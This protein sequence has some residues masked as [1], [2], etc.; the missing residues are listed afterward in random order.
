MALS[1]A[2]R[3]CYRTQ[4]GGTLSRVE[5]IILATI[6]QDYVVLV[7]GAAASASPLGEQRR[8]GSAAY[9]RIR[10]AVGNVR[11]M[12]LDS[13]LAQLASQHD[14]TPVA[15]TIARGEV[16]DA[17][18]ALY[19]DI[20]ENYAS[21][22]E[23]G[24]SSP[25][26]P[27]GQAGNIPA[28]D[29]FIHVG[30]AGAAGDPG[31][32]GV[33]AL[34]RGIREEARTTAARV[35]AL[36]S[37]PRPSS[38]NAGAGGARRARSPSMAAGGLPASSGLGLPLGSTPSSRSMVQASS[39]L[40]FSGLWDQGP[41]VSTGVLRASGTD[42][43]RLRQTRV[44]YAP[45]QQ[46]GVQSQ[47]EDVSDESGFTP[48]ETAAPALSQGDHQRRA[49]QAL[50]PGAFELPANLPN[51][52]A[53]LLQYEMVK[54]LRSMRTLQSSSGSEGSSSDSEGLRRS[55]V[56]KNLRGVFRLRRRCRSSLCVL[57]PAIARGACGSWESGSAATVGCRPLSR[58]RPPPIG[59]T[60]FLAGCSGCGAAMILLLRSLR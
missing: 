18:L 28:P 30:D 15:F 29:S 19:G 27:I 50:V 59:S 32:A 11:V 44:S 6:R 7:A 51:D 34:L 45:A 17:A 10:V 57:S 26:P 56:S 4:L 60:R 25:R 41:G 53:L 37:G 40:G 38:I 8:L 2:S 49:A 23:D 20:A 48:V 33:L 46:H 9:V 13:V 35:A 39:L 14:L 21:L 43:P 42:M 24:E 36:E 52:P 54:T 5:G 58:T 3:I 12:D 1:R 47:D 16:L 22:T 55:S 31:G